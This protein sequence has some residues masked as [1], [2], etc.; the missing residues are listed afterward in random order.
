[1]SDEELVKWWEDLKS[2]DS[3]FMKPVTL[4]SDLYQVSGDDG[5][6]LFSSLKSSKEH[7]IAHIYIDDDSVL[8]SLMEKRCFIEGTEGMR[9]KRAKNSRQKGR[10]TASLVPRYTFVRL[11]RKHWTDVPTNYARPD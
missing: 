6:D 9:S 5:F 10:P 2:I 11:L 7:Y 3:Y 4:S 8:I 1:M